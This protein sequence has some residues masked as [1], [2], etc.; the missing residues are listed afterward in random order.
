MARLKI[1]GP[2]GSPCWAPTEIF[3]TLSLRNQILMQHTS[4]RD[5]SLFRTV[6]VNVTDFLRN[7]AQSLLLFCFFVE[8]ISVY[9]LYFNVFLLDH[10][11]LQSSCMSS[12]YVVFSPL[13]GVL[14]VAAFPRIVF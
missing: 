12:N 8:P 7:T 5:L 2:Q 13:S 10:S 11:R 6:N 3:L 4:L 14:L 9:L 1:I